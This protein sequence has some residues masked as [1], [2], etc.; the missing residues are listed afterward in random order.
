MTITSAA[1][2][3]HANVVA[4][5][6]TALQNAINGLGLGNSLPYTRLASIAY[7]VAG[8]T[9]V[10]SVLLNGGTSDLTATAEQTVKCG[11]PVVA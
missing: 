4:A 10:T 11:N 5:V 9:N 8:V 3:I 7:G 1:G 2:Y 6:V